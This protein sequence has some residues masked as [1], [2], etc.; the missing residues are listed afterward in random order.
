M[1]KNLSLP[2]P[3]GPYTVGLTE[4]ELT[5]TFDSECRRIPLTVFYPASSESC[6]APYSFPE[7]CSGQDCSSVDTHCFTGAP[8]AEEKAPFPCVIYNCC[9]GG[10]TMTNTALCADL[11]SHGYIIVSAGHPGECTAV[12]Y[13]DGKVVPMAAEYIAPM[14]DDQLMRSLAPLLDEMQA[15]DD[16]DDVGLVEL[17]RRFFKLQDVFSARV[18]VW[19]ADTVAAADFMEKANESDPI[20]A[21]KLD[22]SQGIGLTGHSFGGS[23]AMAACRQD[24]RFVC[25]INIDG[26]DFGYHYGEDIAKPFM[27]IGNSSMRKMLRAVYLSNSAPMFQLHTTNIGHQGFT[28]MGFFASDRALNDTGHGIGSRDSTEVCRMLADYHLAFLGKYLRKGVSDVVDLGYEGT[29]LYMRN[30]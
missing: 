3:T 9:Y 15:H 19:V 11:A 10:H 24:P 29:C 30:V 23:T 7:A 14:M 1:Y 27:I 12:R 13:L 16:A 18:E 17:G 2:R 20:L 21:G 8:I 6:P 28:D 22:L 4:R 5:H 26:G 25:G